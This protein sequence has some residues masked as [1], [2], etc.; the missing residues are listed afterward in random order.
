M[1]DDTRFFECAFGVDETLG[2]KCRLLT[3]CVLRRREAILQSEFPIVFP[4]INIL[5]SARWRI[6]SPK[7]VFGVDETPYFKKS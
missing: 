1:R 5:V 4:E 6:R 2:G 3:M 7:Y